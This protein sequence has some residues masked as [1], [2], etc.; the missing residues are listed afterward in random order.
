MIGGIG[1]NVSALALLGAFLLL[2]SSCQKNSYSVF[3]RKYKV[4]FK[5]DTRDVPYSQLT[6][7]GRFLSVRQVGGRLIV[8][9]PD[10]HKTELELT[11][12]ESNTFI[13]G[14]SGLI[15][16]TPTFDNEHQQ[17]WAYDLGCPSCDMPSVRLTVSPVGQATC[18]KC[19]G[20]WDL[21]SSGFPLTDGVRTLYRYPVSAQGTSLTVAN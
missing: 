4:Y 6:T 17:V 8:D 12:L 5:C 20:A 9:D 3:S 14:L 18:P 1:R 11:Q 15:L 10:G 19:H 21:N 16:G 13:M 2:P 7:L